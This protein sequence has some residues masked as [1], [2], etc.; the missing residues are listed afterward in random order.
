M[1]KWP[2]NTT[3]WSKLRVAHLARFPFCEG[4]P[5]HSYKMANT[6][7]HRHPISDG[8]PAFPGHDGLASYCAPCHSAKTARGAEAG[9][10]KTTKARKGCNPDGSPLDPDHPWNSGQTQAT[11]VGTVFPP[12]GA[13]P[14]KGGLNPATLG[15]PIGGKS[16]STFDRA[17]S[18]RAVEGRPAPTPRIELVSKDYRNGC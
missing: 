3:A 5:P 9:A 11:K 10:I 8:G 18:L 1:A 17:K 14:N 16:F 12:L 4:C 7:D 2:Y 13:S 6:V 15:T